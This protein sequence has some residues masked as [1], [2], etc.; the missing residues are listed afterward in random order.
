[1]S[2]FLTVRVD[3][4]IADPAMNRRTVQPSQVQD[5]SLTES[6][7][8]RGVLEPI[9]VR[10]LKRSKTRFELAFG[11]RRLRCAISAGLTEIPVH[12]GEWNDLARD[13]IGPAENL[14]RVE[15]HPVDKWSAVANLAS[16][17]TTA[18]IAAE[19]GLTERE[20]RR[21]LRL[22]RLP[23]ELLQL[24]ELHMPS[25][26]VL[27]ALARASEDQL[28]E[29]VERIAGDEAKRALHL[30]GD[31]SST[32]EVVVL[33]CRTD[34]I[35][36]RHAIFDPQAHFD[37]WEEDL[38][39]PAD[40]LDRM[41]TDQV[42]TFLTLQRQA[43]AERV[44]AQRAEG[45]RIVMAERVSDGLPAYPDGMDLIGTYTGGEAPAA[46]ETIYTAV[47][48]DGRV[49]EV[50]VRA[51]RRVKRRETTAA[52]PGDDGGVSMSKEMRRMVCEAKNEAVRA[53]LAAY[54]P[55]ATTAGLLGVT[56]LS[57][58]AGRMRVD[59]PG[60]GGRTTFEDL[61]TL[62]L[63]PG[64]TPVEWPEDLM[65]KLWA[66]AIGRL[67]ALEPEMLGQAAARGS[68]WVG[69]AI[70]AN[71]HLPRFDTAAVLSEIPV[72]ALKDVA[73][74]AGIDQGALRREAQ[75]MSVPVGELMRNAI[76]GNFENWRPAVAEFGAAAP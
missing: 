21:A 66:D 64:G 3:A 53:G 41:S 40:D 73:E 38:F 70:R 6:I 19:L 10:R 22:G 33:A 37:M 58:C 1:M 24:A 15:A 44:E 69:A 5:A 27:R 30:N 59:A 39:A 46:D 52:A 36:M 34:R 65:R 71:D 74:A 75:Q 9:G 49:I 51:R 31:L 62:L 35:P 23:G 25:E 13:A 32:W 7:K 2:E 60:G 29:A 17:M 54:A 63:E 4:I 48:P 8:L 43:L 20:T 68:E 55:K 61:A 76:A 56:L 72:K 67:V 14:Q 50:L 11:Y 26:R 28:R 42:D 57:L 45:R 12:I 18:G 16:R 47:H